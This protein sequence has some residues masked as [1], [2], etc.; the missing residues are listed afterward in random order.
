MF[1]RASKVAQSKWTK[2]GLAL[3][4]PVAFVGTA[5]ASSLQ[6]EMPQY[7]WE[8]RARFTG[9]DH[10][11]MRRGYQ[12]YKEVCSSCHSMERICYRHLVGV[13]HTEEQAKAEAGAQLVDDINDDGEGIQRAGKLTDHMP[14]PY[15]N[16][17]ASAAANNGAIPP[18]LSLIAKARDGGADYIF[19]LL[20][21]YDREVPAG[22]EVM[23]G[24]HFNPWFPGGMIA[25][26]QPIYDEHVEFADGTPASLP[27]MAKDIAEFLTWCGE[28]HAEEK[29]MWGFNIVFAM[30]IA[31]ASIVYGKR[32]IWNPLKT[33]KVKWKG[34]G[35]HP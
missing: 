21:G 28:P 24:L 32:Y 4:A 27:Q 12:V 1:P 25:M 33:Q 2:L 17:P 18:D 30:S 9:Y 23:P 5:A 8:H 7:T 6:A 14:S 15:P 19:A 31:F 11:S 34:P 35:P 20:C 10:G 29:K 26:P 16:E 22:M 13:T 3:A